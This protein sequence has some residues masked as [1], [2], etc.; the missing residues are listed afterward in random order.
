MVNLYIVRV[1]D[2]D[3]CLAYS[4]DLID[5]ANL[6]ASVGAN[7]ISMSLGGYYPSVTEYVAFDQLNAQ[8]ILSITAAKNTYSSGSV[9]PASYPSIISVAAIK[10][11]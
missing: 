6:C 9:Y 5:A 2:N 11:N 1:F 8:G 3:G 10:S 4:S 7:I